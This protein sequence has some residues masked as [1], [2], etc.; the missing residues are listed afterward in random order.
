MKKKNPAEE[1]GTYSVH[2]GPDDQKIINYLDWNG[3]GPSPILSNSLEKAEELKQISETWD[4]FLSG[5]ITF[6][7]LMRK[8]NN[9]RV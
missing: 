7:E 6:G 8:L 1:T 5:Q 9:I 4:R 3:L 2:F